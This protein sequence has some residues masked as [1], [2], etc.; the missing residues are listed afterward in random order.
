MF[1]SENGIDLLIWNA[2]FKYWNLQLIQCILS[3]M[4]RP[5]VPVNLCRSGTLAEIPIRF[6][7]NFFL[8]INFF[9]ES[10]SVLGFQWTHLLIN[11]LSFNYFKCNNQICFN[12]MM[13]HVGLKH[14]I[15]IAI[16]YLSVLLI[17]IRIIYYNSHW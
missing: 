16:I 7:A 15:T 17:I 2:V 3:F 1:F 11:P 9:N 6:V 12:A 10:G 5:M 13:E 8:Q 4:L 14:I